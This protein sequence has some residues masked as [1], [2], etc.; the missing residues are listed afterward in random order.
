M[1]P[2][3]L[4]PPSHSAPSN[5]S[6]VLIENPVELPVLYSSFPIYCTC[7]S[8]NMKMLLSQFRPPSPYLLV[9][10]S[11]LYICVSIPALELGSLVPFFSR[12]HI[13]V[14]IYSICFSFSD[15]LHS[16]G[17]TLG[18]SMSVQITLFHSFYWLSNIPLYKHVP[19]LYSFIHH[20]TFRLF[21][22]PNCYKQ[23]CSE[24]WGYM[25]PFEL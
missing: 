14:L 3:S 7:D 19:H 23:S 24:R 8:V 1:Y 18:P 20:W 10:L 4:S 17:E 12:F 25:C 13:Y 11:I 15:L 16:I 9:H 5:P 6:K 22:C 2:F 21:A